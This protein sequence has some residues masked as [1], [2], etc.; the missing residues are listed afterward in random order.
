MLIAPEI[1]N[2]TDEERR[3]FIKATCAACAKSFAARTPS[4]PMTTTSPENG[5][6]WMFRPITG[7]CKAE[8]LLKAEDLRG[9]LSSLVDKLPRRSINFKRPGF[10]TRAFSRTLNYREQN[11]QYLRSRL[12]RYAALRCTLLT[13]SECHYRFPSQRR[14]SARDTVCT[15]YSPCLQGVS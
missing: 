11:P 8:D 15:L 12:P 14:G 7:E 13:P 6:L 4:R 5:L 1:A 2:S 9:S 10:S 3:A